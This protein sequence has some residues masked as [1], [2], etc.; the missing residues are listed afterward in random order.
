[1][2]VC[3]GEFA[4]YLPET[5][6]YEERRKASDASSALS[7]S[8]TQV[9]EEYLDAG[10]PLPAWFTRP[11]VARI[12]EESYPRRPAQ[13]VC[14]WLTGLS[15]AGKSTIAEVLVAMLPRYGRR[16][17]LLDGDIV[18]TH[19]SAGLSFDKAGRDANIRHWFAA[20]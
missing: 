18:R 6:A 1:M 10:Q 17:T 3:F 14:I 15:A 16:S 8:G 11:E 4:V 20:E 19:L 13:G 7:I 2:I 5:A 12:L 9:R